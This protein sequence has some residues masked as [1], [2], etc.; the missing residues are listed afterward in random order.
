MQTT[1]N[2]WAFIEKQ[3]ERSKI[4]RYPYKSILGKALTNFILECKERGLS[5]SETM[6][7]IMAH[8]GIKNFLLYFPEEQENLSKNVYIGV[9][10]RYSEERQRGRL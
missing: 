7:G 5:S 10:A 9:C 3:I 4:K 6:G 2:E 1:I 8:R